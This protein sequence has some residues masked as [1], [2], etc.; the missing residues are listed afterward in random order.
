MCHLCPS[1]PWNRF[2]VVANRDARTIKIGATANRFWL[3]LA[4]HRRNGYTEIIR[5][6]ATPSARII[7]TAVLD[8]L[9]VAEI[10]P[11]QGKEYFDL[12]ALPVILDV[13]DG[14]DA[15]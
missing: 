8:A 12:S 3:R 13:A 2:Y 4:D 10:L 1:E 11:V 5:K 6:L 9:R 14:W 7:E 15:A